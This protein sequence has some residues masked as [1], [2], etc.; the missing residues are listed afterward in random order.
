MNTDNHSEM[1]NEAEETKFHIMAK[2]HDVWEMW[3]GS[4]NLCG[5]QKVSRSPHK[6][7]T[8]VGSI[9]DMEEI[10]KARW[11]LFQHDGAAA[12]KLSERSPLPPALSAKDLLGGR[13]QILNVHFILRIN[14]H[15]VESDEDR[16]PERI[17]DTEDWLNWNGELYKQNDSEEN[18]AA[19]NDSDIEHNNRIAVS[20]CPE[21]HD[22]SATPDVHGLVRPTQKSQRMAEKVLA[23]VNAAKTRKNKRGKKT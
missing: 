21:Q 10:V 20:E 23:T 4:Q 1:M 3:Q 5:T 2:V 16:A 17:S 14:R 7:M 11:S 15:P 19:N 13:T 8:A 22:V 6:Q 9:S 18:C 12:F